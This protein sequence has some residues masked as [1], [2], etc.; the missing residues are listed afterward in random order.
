MRS[1]DGSLGN[2][3]IPYGWANEGKSRMVCD[4]VLQAHMWFVEW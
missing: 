3:I 2:C 1:G 4:K